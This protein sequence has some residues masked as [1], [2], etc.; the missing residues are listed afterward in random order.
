MAAES[1]IDYILGIFTET[2]GAVILFLIFV[3]IFLI[4]EFW[5][6]RKRSKGEE[7]MV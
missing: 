7:V 4:A 5:S 6:R 1:F 3:G 2:L